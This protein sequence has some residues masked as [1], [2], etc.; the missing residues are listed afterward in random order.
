M[1]FKIKRRSF[2]SGL[3]KK[4][5]LI[6]LFLFLLGMGFV[7]YGSL[8][9]YVPEAGIG[10]E[11]LAA[12]LGALFVVLATGVQLHQQTDMEVERH[13]KQK[14]YENRLTCYTDLL[15]TKSQFKEKIITDEKVEIVVNQKLL[16]HLV[17]EQEDTFG[18]LEN[19]VKH[20]SELNNRHETSDNKKLNPTE[21]QYLTEAYQHLASMLMLDLK[22]GLKN[23]STAERDAV[24]DGK[25]YLSS[26]PF[27]DIDNTAKFDGTTFNTSRRNTSKIEF[28][29]VEYTKKLYVYKVL[30]SYV[31]DE[32]LTFADLQKTYTDEK[33]TEIYGLNMK[34]AKHQF[35][36]ANPFWLEL[37]QAHA[38]KNKSTEGDRWDR[39]WID[40]DMLLNFSDGKTIAIRNGQD[41]KS[42]EI[43]QKWCVHN[44]IPLK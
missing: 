2:M 37:D 20:I 8:F 4:I 36:G 15:K 13:K 26:D 43:F 19:F 38:K 30:K 12:A 44:E 32:G 23:L 28:K 40:E 22:D 3:N 14:T 25:R 21:V 29:G 33:L 10:R 9:G 7:S 27:T 17:C 5:L 6:L 18:A 42:I 39:Y 1:K 16:A 34:D 35:N 11:A 41:T 24:E 31:D